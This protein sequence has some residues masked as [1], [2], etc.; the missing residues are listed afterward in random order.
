MGRQIRLILMQL[1][2]VI[3]LFSAMFVLNATKSEEQITKVVF[4]NSP[5]TDV[6]S[7]HIQ[8][9]YGNLYVDFM[10]GGYVLGEV[11]IDVVDMERFVDMM[12][13]AAAVYAVTEIKRPQS[14]DVYGLNNKAAVID[15]I[16]IDGE[17]MTL[18]IGN[19]E[20]ISKGYY[21]SISDFDGVYLIGEERVNGFKQPEKYFISNYIT[22]LMPAQSQ[23]SLGH[24]KMMTLEG[25]TLEEKVTLSPVVA[26]NEQS[27]LDASS[28]GSASHLIEINGM[29]HRVDERYASLVF[30]SVLGLKAEDIIDYNLSEEAM[31]IFGFDRPDMEVVFDYKRTPDE[32]S[33]RYEIKILEKSGIFY[34]SCNKRGVI[35][36]ISPPYFYGVTLEQF[37]VR[38]FFSPLLF[39]LEA[40]EIQRA[41]E[42]YVFELSGTT[43]DDLA[44]TCNGESFDLDRFR[45]FYKLI[46]S[47]AHD[48]TMDEQIELPGLSLMNITYRYRDV[49][50]P[51][52]EL[53]LYA[54][55]SRRIYAEVNGLTE[56]TI[57][58]LFYTRVSQALDILFTEEVFEIEW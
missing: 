43:N 42:R 37:P 50:K 49:N 40:L 1:G 53:N 45:R 54:A 31:A 32:E 39:D 20:P 19:Y 4:R 7:V 47:A 44:V 14:L 18:T 3:I 35:Y 6:R 46:T 9:E 38:W 33:V 52:D 34:A 51:D 2:I 57:K 13:D 5:P 15:V 30:D 36:Q 55:E 26:E 16:Y 29:N 21:C 27:M 28:F 25:G 12:T 56:F 23:S 17:E 10:D 22:P 41:D 11:P 24:V 8:N 48:N 58:E